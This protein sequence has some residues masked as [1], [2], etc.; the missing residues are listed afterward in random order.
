LPSTALLPV[1]ILFL[2]IGDTMKI[3]VIFYASFWPILLNTID[4]VRNVD[5]ILI[6]TGKTFGLEERE[7]LTK[8]LL[9]SASPYIVSGLKVSS[10]MALALV[11]TSEMIAGSSGLGYF[12]LHSQRVFKVKQVYA[13]IAV[14]AL[15]GYLLG[16]CFSRIENKYLKWN[17]E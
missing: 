16:K 14:I 10:L 7:I 17:I 9:P 3:F 11:I 12:I 1:L 13:G 5:S 2:G 6:S 15:I 4:G 8:V